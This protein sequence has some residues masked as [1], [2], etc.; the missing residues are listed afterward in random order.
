M[1]YSVLVATTLTDD[2]L[3]FLRD[4]KDIEV[5]IIPPELKQVQKLIGGADALIIRDDVIVDAPL[6]ANAKRLKVIGRSGVGLAGIDVESATARGV[7]V[8][9]T[10]GANAV[11]TSEYTFGMMLALCRNIIPAHLDVGKGTWSRHA[12]LGLELYGKTLGLIGLGRV[13]RSVAERAIAFGM[14]VL[15]YDPYVSEF[16]VSELRVKLVGLDEVL[17]RS[18]VI[19]LHCAV[20]PE[21]YQ[22]LGANALAQVKRGVRII[23]VAHG[24]VIDEKALADALKSGVVAGAALDVFASHP[25]HGRFDCRGPKRSQHPDCAAGL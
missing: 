9:N 24:S 13:G 20:T 23:N 1:K 17:V 19:S 7:I 2:A 10:P 21:T 14:D 11:A 12:H 16:Q 5:Q 4:A 15:A 25:A 6:L 3:D 18:D 22:I 8:M